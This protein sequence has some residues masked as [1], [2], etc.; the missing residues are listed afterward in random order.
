MFFETGNLFKNLSQC[1]MLTNAD[2][3]E[4]KQHFFYHL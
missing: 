4:D 3:N 1:A 2:I